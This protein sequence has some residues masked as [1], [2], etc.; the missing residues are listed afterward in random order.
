[1]RDSKWILFV[2]LFASEV[3]IAQP[4]VEFINHQHHKLGLIQFV[5]DRTNT[6]HNP[7]LNSL[8]RELSYDQF[9]NKVN[10]SVSDTFYIVNKE[11]KTINILSIRGLDSL[12][13]KYPR[14]IAPGDTARV[15]YSKAFNPYE[16]GVKFISELIILNTDLGEIG[17][18][19]LDYQVMSFYGMMPFY[20]N[21]KLKGYCLKVHPLGQ[22]EWRYFIGED[23]QIQSYGLYHRGLKQALGKWEIYQ[24]KVRFKDTFYH[25]CLSF[26][27]YNSPFMMAKHFEVKVKSQGVWIEPEHF[28]NAYE[29]D[30]IML[31]EYDSLMVWSNDSTDTRSIRYVELKDY[32]IK[33]VVLVLQDKN[34]KLLFNRS[35]NIKSD[36]S[37]NN[38][39]LAMDEPYKRD[40]YV[41]EAID[42]YDIELMDSSDCKLV[43]NRS[44]LSKTFLH[45]LEKDWK[46]ASISH[47]M[48]TSLYL[49]NHI[50][51]SNLSEEEETILYRMM[52]SN[53]FEMIHYRSKD[54][55]IF[56]YKEKVLI[57]NI[58]SFY[59]TLTSRFSNATFSPILLEI[60]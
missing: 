4:K 60:K 37:S 25:K 33:P 8:Y 9:K 5:L 53:G 20:E 30:V 41:L 43:F 10:F 45:K 29:L 57:K 23:N 35:L 31:P 12:F 40:I 50:Y 44:K 15:Y 28:K 49:L 14:Q 24:D 51:I 1:M 39:L 19:K 2:A 16:S 46:V 54:F 47:E 59:Q 13:L 17:P 56:K 7:V 3:L 48:D 52:S 27:V 42:R 6:D 32:N 58:L 36:F 26:H 34:T 38:F 11:K 18:I 22:T 21:T 55:L